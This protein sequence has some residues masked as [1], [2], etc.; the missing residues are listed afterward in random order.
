M[1]TGL[2]LEGGAM[3]GLFTCGV[4]DVLLENDIRFVE[5]PG[6][7]WVDNPF[8][9]R[10]LAMAQSIVYTDD[11]YYCYR[12]D[13]ADASSATIDPLGMICRWHE[14]EDVLDEL[15][16]EDDSIRRANA[17]VALRYLSRIMAMGALLNH[18]V[19]EAA[20]SMARRLDLNLVESVHEVKPDVIRCCRALAGQVTTEVP[21]LPYK[22]HLAKEGAWALRN[23]GPRFLLHNILLSRTR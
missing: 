16:I 1:K 8:A 15:G 10:T 20:Q 11:A 18:E 2:I 17:V 12:E 23:N 9:V 13:L 5:A 6:A 7:G 14:R 4:L 22:M 21:E 3:R 19:L